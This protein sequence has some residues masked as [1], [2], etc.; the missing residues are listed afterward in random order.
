MVLIFGPK[1]GEPL[2]LRSLQRFAKD[3]RRLCSR[4]VLA[5][6]QRISRLMNFP[7]LQES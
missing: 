4:L 1:N 5:L 2:K 7:I 3:A 6:V